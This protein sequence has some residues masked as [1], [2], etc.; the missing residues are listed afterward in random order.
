MGKAK[1]TTMIQAVKVLRLK[2][3][4]ARKVLPEHLHRYL[5]LERILASSWYP[6]EDYLA[7]LRALAK[8]SPDP[9]MDIYEFMGLVWARIDLGRR[10]IYAHLIRRGDPATTLRRTSV[11]WGLYHDTGKEEVVES[12]DNYVVTEIFGYKHPSREVCSIVKGWNAELSTLAGGKEV[13][14][15]H[16]RCVLAGASACRF[17]VTW[18][19]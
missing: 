8:V 9:G 1:G 13:R 17:K 4:E 12:G 18:T 19:R 7:I 11:V 16:E 10:G 5:D 15:D 14:V 6:E 3:D 2:K